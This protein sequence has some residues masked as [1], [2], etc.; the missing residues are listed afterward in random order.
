MNKTLRKGIRMCKRRLALVL[1][2][3]LILGIAPK[4]TVL[5]ATE[6]QGQQ[7]LDA[8]GGQAVSGSSASVT[9]GLL[10]I[11]I[12]KITEFDAQYK[13]IVNDFKLMKDNSNITDIVQSFDETKGVIDIEGN[14]FVIAARRIRIDN[15]NNYINAF[16]M[17]VDLL[18]QANKVKTAVKAANDAN[19]AWN[20]HTT[21]DTAANTYYTDFVEK[22]L[23]A[24]TAISTY[25]TKFVR[26]DGL[27]VFSKCL[28]DPQDVTLSNDIR[29]KRI[30]TEL[31]TYNTLLKKYN[32]EKSYF[33]NKRTLEL[34]FKDDDGNIIVDDDSASYFELILEA[35]ANNGM[36]LSDTDSSSIIRLLHNGSNIKTFLN[37]YN[38]V[39][40][41]RS[42][43]K[44]IPTDKTPTTQSELEAISEANRLY[45]RLTDTQKNM[46]SST[47]Y[48]LL[49]LLAGS[50]TKIQT[51]N[52][53]I[54]AIAMPKTGDDAS[55]K[56]FSDAYKEA[57]T[58]YND[59][60]AEYYNVPN[61]DNM[62]SELPTLKGTLTD[63]YKF[64][65]R[66][67]E[68]L[69]L[70]AALVCENYN[71]KINPIK[72]DYAALPAT[73][74]NNIY[75]YVAFD[76]L[77]KNAETAYDIRV[78]IDKLSVGLVAEHGTEVE[79]IRKAL[80]SSNAQVKAYVGTTYTNK[81][82]VYQ[83]NIEILNGNMAG[84]VDT[85]IDMIGTVTAASKSKIETAEQAY[86]S[87]TEEQKMQVKK[88]AI[89]VQARKEYNTLRMDLKN[90]FVSGI[91]KGY[92][93]TH[94]AI[95][96][97]PTVIIDDAVLTKGVDYTITYANNKN[98]GTARVVITAIEGSGYRG[99]FT[100]S[101]QIVKDS[102]S[103]ASISSVAKSYKY[104]G[105]KIKPV[106]KVYC[107][108]YKLKKGTDYTVTYKNNKKKGTAKI[109][110]KG[111]GNYKGSKTKTFKIVK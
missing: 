79:A 3:S 87:L 57:M 41:F 71:T 36:N 73:V 94:S 55:Y 45:D 101:F 32:I 97:N 95:R 77:R 54:K 63:I 1:V 19:I 82:L 12:D 17:I 8:I 72:T 25:N 96:P 70:N 50:N 81:L 92:V 51:L 90:A 83:Y 35:I 18:K 103:G 34:L 88:Y 31:D 69:K 60:S 111:K 106:P 23:A 105:K 78:R 5:A 38:A 66:I 91:K 7:L 39:K 6:E 4:V 33:E 102:L 64:T 28:G 46:V 86:A 65:E 11:R 14:E 62:I 48:N 2:M 76:E 93:Y 74:K 85:L 20:N 80:D 109:I 37:N 44:S 58:L 68:V 15:S 98:V 84:A 26:M 29:D 52:E 49:Q 9:G 110:V 59:L 27:D 21:P 61:F 75:N 89:L 47:E 16:T 42:Q 67:N 22:I 104:T 56:K 99:T 30:K 24:Q 43:L 100:K 107:N 13:K 53:K 108:G 40:A 10:A